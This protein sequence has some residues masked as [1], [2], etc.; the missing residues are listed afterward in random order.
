[1][2]SAR[3]PRPTSVKVG[4][5]NYKIKYCTEVDWERYGNDNEAGGL[6]RNRQQEIH[7]L[8]IHDADEVI[9]QEV[10]LHEIQHAVWSTTMMSH[11][12]FRNDIS[13]GEGVEEVAIRMTTPLLMMVLRDNP[14]VFRYITSD[15]NHVR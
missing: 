2:A 5:I 14:Q 8:L 13:D 11:H 3:V 12:D 15:G 10:L 4:I 7:V 9:Y 1:M 6:T